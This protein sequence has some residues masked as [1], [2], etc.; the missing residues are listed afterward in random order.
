VDS[1][2]L[3][4]EGGMFFKM[5]GIAKLLLSIKIKMDRILNINVVKTSDLIPLSIVHRGGI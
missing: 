3:E 5:S 4:V 1:F 2:T